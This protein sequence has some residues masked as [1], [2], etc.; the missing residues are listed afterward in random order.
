MP[1]EATPVTTTPV[2]FASS[3]QMSLGLMLPIREGSMGGE[4]PRFDDLV[5]MAMAARDVGFEAIW[6]ADHFTMGAEDEMAGVWEAWTMMAAVAARVP[7]VQIGPLV[8]CTGFRNPGVIAKMAEA[9]DEIS[10][11]RFIL[12]IGAGWNELEYRQFGFPFDYRASRFEDAFQIVHSLL[13]DGQA[14][15]QGRFF[16]ANNAVNIPRGPRTSGLPL[17]IGSNGDRLLKTVARYA[18]AWNSDWEAGPEKMAKLIAKVDA[19]CEAVGRD[20]AS[21]VKTGSARFA[22]DDQDASRTDAVAGT[23]DEMAE[24]LVAFQRLGLRHFVCGLEPRTLS[25]VEAFGDVITAFD[26][27]Q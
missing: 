5:S 8:T 12:G 20:P 27:R 23:V 3:R 1:D 25:E 16:Q 17:L 4:T 2:W 6:F 13:R 7:D 21:L 24:R 26:G 18:D 22:M 14:D 10:G 15:Y 9:M 19:A 11:G